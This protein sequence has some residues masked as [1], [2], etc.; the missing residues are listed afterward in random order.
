VARTNGI[1]NLREFVIVSTSPPVLILAL[2]VLA[3]KYP[4][5]GI[6]RAVSGFGAGGGAAR[7]GSASA[8]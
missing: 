7:N 3:F 1:V 8:S 6:L 4:K 2:L 5:N